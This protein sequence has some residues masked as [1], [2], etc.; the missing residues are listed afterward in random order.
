MNE[1]ILTVAIPT[2]NR[3]E[4]IRT[5][6]MT[7]LP[8][9]NERVRLVVYDNCSFPNIEELFNDK[10]LQRFFLVKNKVNVGGDANIARC[11]ENCETKWL[12]TLSDDDFVKPDSIEYILNILDQSEDTVFFN[13]QKD[14][15]FQSS[16][17]ESLSSMFKH[18]S[19][20][21]SSFTMSSCIYN[22]EKLKPSL[23]DYYSN[24]SSM[25]GTII[26]V[27]KYVERNSQA[28]CQF[29]DYSLINSYNKEVGWDYR[30]FIK[31]SILF[32]YAFNSEKKDAK[33]YNKTLFLGYFLTNY[34]LIATNRNKN[35]VSKKERLA[36]LGL[37]IWRQGLLS[38][39]IYCPKII[40]KTFFSVCFS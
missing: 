15:S 35:S 36:L 18:P 29:L 13:F 23:I 37:N 32:V 16:D 2:Y 33:K 30:T 20:F 17:F 27:L 8:Q 31:K 26:L 1:T 4:A 14:L 28:R 34:W 21:S 39:F 11:F 5:Q 12:W 40:I 24:L 9:L 22:I 7:L 25:V 3:P 10:E 38:A 19:V 6:V